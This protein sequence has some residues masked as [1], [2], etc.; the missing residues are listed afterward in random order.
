MRM[1]TAH[2]WC[3][4]ICGQISAPDS[5]RA[6]TPPARAT[7]QINEKHAELGLALAGRCDSVCSLCGH[8]VGEMH[9]LL[10]C[11]SDRVAALGN[12]VQQAGKR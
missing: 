5:R 12:R 7:H 1:A 10:L 8:L 6:R 9:E 11:H 4:R 2:T 3:R